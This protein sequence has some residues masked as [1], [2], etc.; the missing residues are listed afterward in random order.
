MVFE[1]D[2]KLNWGLWQAY[3]LGP[4]L[5]VTVVTVKLTTNKFEQ[6]TTCAVHYTLNQRQRQ[7]PNSSHIP[8]VSYS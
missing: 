7:W 8:H 4:R 5:M 3:F 6:T 1:D 2:K